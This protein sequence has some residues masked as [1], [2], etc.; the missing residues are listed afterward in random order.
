M[1]DVDKIQKRIDAKRQQLDKLYAELKEAK[2][3]RLWACAGCGLEIVEHRMTI[4]NELGSTYECGEGYTSYI[5]NRFWVC[6][7]CNSWTV[8]DGVEYQAES[9]D[10]SSKNWHDPTT[11]LGRLLEPE[12][13]R[14]REE[15]EATMKRIELN[16]ARELLRRAGEL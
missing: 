13:K 9:L 14:V 2:R 16:Q 12:L 6:A 5:K 7:K 10:W 15:R 8:A 3:Q 11:N 1:T 4:I